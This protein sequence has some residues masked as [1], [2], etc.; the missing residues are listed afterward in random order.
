MLEKDLRAIEEE[1]GK[2]EER[3]SHLEAEMAKPEVFG[4]FEKLQPIQ[5]DF[6]QVEN[7]LKEANER[8]D[9][10]ATAIDKLNKS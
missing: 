10:V 4:N 5:L 7:E 3:R 2:L 8:W 9:H 1:V 6:E